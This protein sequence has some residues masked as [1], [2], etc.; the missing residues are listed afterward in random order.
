MLPQCH[1]NRLSYL[2]SPSSLFILIRLEYEYLCPNNTHFLLKVSKTCIRKQ[3]WERM[4]PCVHVIM[5]VLLSPHINKDYRI[6]QATVLSTVFRQYT[7]VIFLH[8]YLPKRDTG[9]RVREVGVLCTM[10][11]HMTHWMTEWV[12][13]DNTFLWQCLL[14]NSTGRDTFGWNSLKKATKKK[15]SR[16]SHR[17]WN[18]QK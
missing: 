18:T 16:H 9:I 3:R 4:W 6:W 2:Q 10:A 12:N 5:D 8:V 13:Y 11:K 1:L 14:I 7:T 17:E 15:T